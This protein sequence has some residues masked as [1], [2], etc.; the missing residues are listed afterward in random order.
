MIR[1]H[2]LNVNLSAEEAKMLADIAEAEGVSQSA[3]IRQVI[4]AAARKLAKGGK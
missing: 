1:D 2:K 4:R 3:W